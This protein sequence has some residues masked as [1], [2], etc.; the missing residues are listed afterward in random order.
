MIIAFNTCIEFN[1]KISMLLSKLIKLM[2]IIKILSN[3]R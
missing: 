2:Q 1:I 3:K